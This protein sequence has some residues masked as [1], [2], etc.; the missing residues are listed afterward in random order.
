MSII[1]SSTTTKRAFVIG[2]GAFIGIQAFIADLPLALGAEFGVSSRFDT[3]V[4][5]KTVNEVTGNDTQTYYSSAIEN[6]PGENVDY[7]SLKARTGEI[8]GQFRFTLT[9]YFK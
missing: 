9:Y 1:S 7:D 3:G 5:Y 6:L 2:I 4:K 8:G